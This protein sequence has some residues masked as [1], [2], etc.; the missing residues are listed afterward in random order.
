[1]RMKILRHAG[2]LFEQ[3]DKLLAAHARLDL[4][5]LALAA[6]DIKGPEAGDIAALHDSR[7]GCELRTALAPI[8]PV[9]RRKYGRPLPHGDCPQL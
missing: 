7:I 8:A 2:L 6:P 4:S 3:L 9:A 5:R 1:M